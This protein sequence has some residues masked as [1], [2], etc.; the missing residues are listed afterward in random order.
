MVSGWVDVLSQAEIHSFIDMSSK[1]RNRN[2]KL[3]QKRN[4]VLVSSRLLNINILPNLFLLVR[5][6]GLDG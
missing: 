5:T 4:R 6:F 2:H 1:S 3:V